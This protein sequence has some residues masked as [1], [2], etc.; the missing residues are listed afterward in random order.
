MTPSSLP[1]T[2]NSG[3]V[4][5][6]EARIRSLLLCNLPCRGPER[7]ARFDTERTGVLFFSRGRGRGHAIPDITI[8]EE[9]CRLRD[10]LD[11]L[12]VSYATGADTLAEFGFTVIDLG[13]TEDNLVWNTTVLAGRLIQ[14]LRPSLV[15]AHEEFAALVATGVLGVPAVFITHWFLETETFAMQSLRH[16]NDIVFIDRPGKFE[17]PAQVAEKIHYVG[18]IVRDFAYSR[19]DRDRCRLELGV[20]VE[21]TVITVLPGSW[22]EEIAPIF[23]LVLEAVRLLRIPS[24]KLLWLAGGD[25]RELSRCSQSLDWVVVIETE[26]QVDRLIAASDVVITK[27]NRNTVV[28][29][30]HLGIPS[31]S[32]TYHLNPMDDLSIANIPTNTSLEASTLHPERLADCI[33]KELDGRSSL[34][35]KGSLFCHRRSAASTAANIIHRRLQSVL[36]GQHA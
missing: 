3:S 30:C 19:S 21:A 17:E 6:Q 26:W 4:E 27:A 34:F 32:L 9:L 8:V 12:F 28:E 1:P 24:K 13:L 33:R 31:I 20:S 25:Y 14:S 10:D 22:S 36:G 5:E 35:H 15:V 16:A 11:I 7:E 29:V 23:E 18:P 2:K